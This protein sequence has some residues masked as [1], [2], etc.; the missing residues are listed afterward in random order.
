MADPAALSQLDAMRGNT[1]LSASCHALS[2]TR[3]SLP[4]SFARLPRA[5]SV[6]V[7]VCL[8]VGLSVSVPCQLSFWRV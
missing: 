6:S 5:P 7:S 4:P 1:W 2:P 3:L 8:S